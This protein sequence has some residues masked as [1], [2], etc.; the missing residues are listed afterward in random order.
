M[1]NIIKYASAWLIKNIKIDI[2]LV[3]SLQEILKDDDSLLQHPIIINKIES[4]PLDFFNRYIK[5]FPYKK[6]G[7]ISIIDLYY[8]IRNTIYWDIVSSY[9][10]TEH[11]KQLQKHFEN[12]Q[13]ELN[14]Y[15]PKLVAGWLAYNIV[16]Y[17]FS[18]LVTISNILK[19][20]NNDAATSY[21]NYLYD[22]HINISDDLGIEYF[23]YYNLG[24]ISIGKLYDIIKD[25]KYW[26]IISP[27]LTDNHN[28]QLIKYLTKI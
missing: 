4:I 20:D 23:H 12:K 7:N 22:Y 14:E 6:W 21:I 24:N 2:L 5:Y 13:K 28:D 16:P 8:K 10:T 9:F 25:T 11:I 27:I 17:D 3:L 19:D 26:E 15:I 1:D 18:L